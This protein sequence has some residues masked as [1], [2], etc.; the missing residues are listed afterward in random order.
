MPRQGI[1][2]LLRSVVLGWIFVEEEWEPV[3]LIR[4]TNPPCTPMLRPAVQLR[5][6]SSSKCHNP[7]RSVPASEGSPSPSEPL[8]STRP[9]S[10][11][12]S[13]SFRCGGPVISSSRT[14][15]KTPVDR[16]PVPVT[17][18]QWYRFGRAG[19][20]FCCVNRDRGGGCGHSA[21]VAREKTA[22]WWWP[23]RKSGTR[24]PLLVFRP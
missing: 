5:R 14:T 7:A 1:R 2:S 11:S 3:I 17:T 21:R 12:P 6:T 24:S 22:K 18:T 16:I 23:G 13:V 15:W 4:P 9:Q 8:S 10:P 20:G 19:G